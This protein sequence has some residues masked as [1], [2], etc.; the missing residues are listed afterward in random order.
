MQG[1]ADV[2]KILSRYEPVEWKY[3]GLKG[4][5][6]AWTLENGGTSHDPSV[7]AFV[8]ALAAMTSCAW[9]REI[10]PAAERPAVHPWVERAR[11]LRLAEAS[12][13]RAL[14]HYR[15]DSIGGGATSLA[16]DPDFFRSERGKTDPEA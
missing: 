13:W 3:D 7:L 10:D 12:Q 1:D 15:S 4:K 11:E 5:I 2:A 6:V 16:D 8:V 9:G 14:L